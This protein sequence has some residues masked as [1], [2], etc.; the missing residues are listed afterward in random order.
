[1]DCSRLL[2]GQLRF[3]GM[4][5]ARKCS[6]C[7][8]R[9][10]TSAL[11]RLMAQKRGRGFAEA[12][13]SPLAKANELVWLVLDEQPLGRCRLQALYQQALVQLV[14]FFKGHGRVLWSQNQQNHQPHQGGRG[15]QDVVG[16]TDAGADETS[17]DAQFKKRLI[18][19][20]VLAQELFAPVM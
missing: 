6:V 10:Y 12:Q 9:A 5:V 1:M 17:L 4:V 16:G 20:V 13:T 14:Y 2:Y 19:G 15:G 11:M 8:R 18:G 7:I 3:D